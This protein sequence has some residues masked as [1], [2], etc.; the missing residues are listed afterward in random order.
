MIVKFK[1]AKLL[2]FKIILSSIQAV[3][4]CAGLVFITGFNTSDMWFWLYALVAIVGAYFAVKN[5]DEL[6]RVIK[7]TLPS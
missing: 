5:W 2:I 1:T 6:T 7:Q 4:G 3:I